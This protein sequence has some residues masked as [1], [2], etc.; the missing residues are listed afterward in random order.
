MTFATAF[1]LPPAAVRRGDS[2]RVQG[3][4]NLAKGLY[5][6][7][8]IISARTAATCALMACEGGS[9]ESAP[10]SGSREMRSIGS[11]R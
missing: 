3:G 2:A 11:Q 1:S 10:A 7:P 6:M 9:R 4:G 5:R 8:F